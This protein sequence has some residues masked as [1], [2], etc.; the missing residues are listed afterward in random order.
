MSSH[1]ETM[2]DKCDSMQNALKQA[3]QEIENE[4]SRTQ[5]YKNVF[6]ATMNGP[7]DISEKDAH[8]HAIKV[9]LTNIK[10]K[11]KD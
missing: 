4:I 8:K 2:I 7:Y 9:C 11:L 3:R 5:E 10:K 6:E 1:I